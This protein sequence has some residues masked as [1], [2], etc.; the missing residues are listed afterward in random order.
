MTLTDYYTAA[1]IRPATIEEW[2]ESTAAAKRDG[3]AGA[4]LV[5][6]VTVYVQGDPVGLRVEGGETEED[7]EAG[8]VDEVDG[9]F[10]VVAWD[11]GV[12]TRSHFS[13]LTL[14]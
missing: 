2:A 11:Q 10:L 12:R 8:T 6:G 4:I 1:A 14:A 3:G 5:D 13:G 9:E 7:H